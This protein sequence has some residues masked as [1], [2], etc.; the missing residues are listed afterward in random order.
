[1]FE[2]VAEVRPTRPADFD[3][4]VHAVIEFRALPEAGALAV[5][6]KRIRNLLRKAEDVV[7]ERVDEARL[8]AAAEVGLHRALQDKE[9]EVGPLLAA[10]DYTETLRRLAGL[11]EP[12][13]RFFDEVMVMVEDDAVRTNRLALLGS[14]Y[15]L[16]RRVA[17]VGQLGG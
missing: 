12:V 15:R 17:D 4:R 14:L 3:R 13:D 1:V 16:F 5:A 7:P 9:Q 8:A 2:A 10:G 11:R 6:N